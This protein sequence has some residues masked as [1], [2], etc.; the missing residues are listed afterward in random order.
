MAVLG[1]KIQRSEDRTDEIPA[2]RSKHWVHWM[3]TFAAIARESNW[4]T[5]G[6]SR[7]RVVSGMSVEVL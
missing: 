4:P 5:L 7:P 2:A 6:V 1:L 3:P